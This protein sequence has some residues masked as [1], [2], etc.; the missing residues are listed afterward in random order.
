M[1]GFNGSVA[2]F[3]FGIAPKRYHH[4]PGPYG[5][6]DRMSSLC[7]NP[8]L[9][10]DIISTSP[11]AAIIALGIQFKQSRCQYHSSRFSVHRHEH[12][13]S[14]LVNFRQLVYEARVAN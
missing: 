7:V 3:V 9:W 2:G 4:R 11:G 5:Q 14:N 10:Y 8:D 6:T 1:Y 12:I 13:D